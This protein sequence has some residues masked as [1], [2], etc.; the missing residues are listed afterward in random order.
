MKCVFA[1][2]NR[3]KVRNN[4]NQLGY[5]VLLLISMLNC[6]SFRTRAIAIAT[7]N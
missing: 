1:E 7:L 3:L 5:N 4:E 2:R 6:Q